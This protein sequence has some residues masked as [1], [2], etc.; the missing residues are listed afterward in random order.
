MMDQ[1]GVNVVIDGHL[2]FYRDTKSRDS[3]S[4]DSMFYELKFNS[5]QGPL[6]SSNILGV[7]DIAYSSLP[8]WFFSD[9]V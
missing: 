9:P 5:L 3:K 4:R 1:K 6:D 2:L 8:S 7:N